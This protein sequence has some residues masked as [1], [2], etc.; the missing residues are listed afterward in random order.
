MK[1]SKGEY[2]NTREMLFCHKIKSM[3]KENNYKAIHLF[4]WHFVTRALIVHNTDDETE[5]EKQ[6]GP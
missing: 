1:K 6:S 5:K 4:S 3:E 2:K